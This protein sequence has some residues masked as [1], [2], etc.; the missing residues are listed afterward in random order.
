MKHLLLEGDL[1]CLLVVVE[2]L[3]QLFFVVV[4]ERISQGYRLGGMTLD[5]MLDFYNML[6]ILSKVVLV[7]TMHTYFSF[8]FNLMPLAF[9]PWGR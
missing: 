6:T 2:D 9:E 4:E 7:Q 8:I 5:I 1:C 3:L